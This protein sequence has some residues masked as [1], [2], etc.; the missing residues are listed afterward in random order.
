MDL[1]K[2]AVGAGA[3]VLALG[4]AVPT[5]ANGGGNKYAAQA[6]TISCD[7]DQP[8]GGSGDT[9]TLNGP[10]KLWPP[11][12]KFVDEPVTATSGNSNDNVTISLTPTAD[13]AAGGDGGPQHDPDF[14]PDQP[15]GNGTGSATASMQLR[16][17]R[18]GKGDGRTYI[19]DW[20][21][22]FGQRSCTSTDGSH[23]AFEV[24]VPHDMRGGA[25]WNDAAT[26]Q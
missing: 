24:T 1:M 19:I 13:D 9:V 4:V 3:L 12:H 26:K 15:A 21:A 16:A 10:L 8:G 20:T 11:N 14:T 7:D 17:E 22:M 6:T 5:M 2:P 25:D 18:S 23:P